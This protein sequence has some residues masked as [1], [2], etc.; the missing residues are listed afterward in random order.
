[1]ERTLICD[2]PKKVGEKVKVAGGVHV[3]RSHGKINFVDII[4]RSGTLQVVGGKELK[5]LKPQYSIEVEGIINKR[6]PQM[7]NEKIKTGEIE[8]SLEKLKVLAKAEEMPF[9]MGAEDLNLELPTLLDFRALTLRHPK[10]KEIFK[11]QAN[12]ARA[13]REKA[14]E[15]GC[16]EVFSPTVSAS[17]TEGGA[18]VFKIDYYGH[19]AFLV[20]SPQLYKQIM[21]PVMERVYLFSHAYR[22]EPSVTT[23]H[24]SEVVQLDCEIGY[25]KNFEELLDHLE[26]V[27]VGMIKKA[28]EYSKEQ[29]KIFGVD[30]PLTPLKIPRLKLREAQEILAKERQTERRCDPDLTPEDERDICVWAKREHKSDFVTI[31]HFPTKK[32]AFYSMPDPADTEF[33]LSYDLLFKGLEICSGS[34]RINDHDQLVEVMKGR[35]ID[36]KDFEMYLQAFKYGMPPEGGFSFGLERTTMKLLNLA[37]VREASLFPR[38]MERIDFRFSD[39]REN[40]TMQD[41][42]PIYQEIINLL[43]KNKINYKRYEHKPVF[44]SEDSAKVRGTTVH[45]GAKALVLDSN[46]GLVLFV[47]PADLMAD[48]ESIQAKCNFSKLKMASKETVRAKTGLEVGSIPP[49]GSLIGLKTYLDNRLSDNEEIAFNVGRNDR[50]VKMK[51][52]DFLKIEKPEVIE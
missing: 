3:V 30:M 32:R 35:K 52:S 24:L 15:L 40:D 18:E 19:E 31:T 6:P 26:Y 49:F 8:L 44:T 39:T 34:Q 25:I 29:L 46:K 38:D 28:A 4:D 12:V 21:V 22:M 14:E 20:Q 43:N 36:P 17:A 5:D 37:N 42:K 33:S 9:D 47:L 7:A 23:R 41:K 50:S 27:G 2:T 16:I 10:Q 45:Q 51:Y 48:L 13:F 11:V 1:M